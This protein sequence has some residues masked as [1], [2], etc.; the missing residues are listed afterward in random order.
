MVPSLKIHLYS[1]HSAVAEKYKL[2]IFLN[3]HTKGKKSQ[4]P[5]PLGYSDI[6]RYTHPRQK[7]K[8]SVTRSKG[9]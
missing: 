8:V 5:D 1:L 2:D 6:F 7:A 9:T 3:T 4:V